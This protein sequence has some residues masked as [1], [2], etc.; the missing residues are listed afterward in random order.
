MRT[1]ARYAELDHL[2]KIL[3][4]AS[5]LPATAADVAFPI[6]KL[7]PKYGAGLIPTKDNASLTRTWRVGGRP[8]RH[9]EQRSRL[10]TRTS[11]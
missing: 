3:M 1:Y 6:R 11:I 8:F 10:Q 4:T 2:P 7:C 9:N 5:S